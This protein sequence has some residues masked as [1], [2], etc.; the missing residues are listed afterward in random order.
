MWSGTFRPSLAGRTLAVSRG[1]SCSAASLLL[2]C[3]ASPMPCCHPSEPLIGIVCCF[4][5]CRGRLVCCLARQDTHGPANANAAPVWGC[6]CGTHSHSYPRYFAKRVHAVHNC[7]DTTTWEAIIGSD[8]DKG[9]LAHM[10]DGHFY[11]SYCEF[12]WLTSVGASKA[13]FL[14]ELRSREKKQFGNVGAKLKG[15]RASPPSVFSL[16]WVVFEEPGFCGE[17]YLL[18]KGLYG[19]PEDWGALQPR[20]ASAMPV[21]LVRA[22][23]QTKFWNVLLCWGNL[24][25]LDT[26]SHCST[27]FTWAAR[28]VSHNHI[29]LDFNI[30]RL[31]I[32]QFCNIGVLAVFSLPLVVPVWLTKCFHRMWPVMT[33]ILVTKSK[34]KRENR[35]LWGGG[36]TSL[37]TVDYVWEHEAQ[38]KQE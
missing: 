27:A 16:S 9:L 34:F 1:Y 21:V 3:T 14:H 30:L 36:Q 23:T 38:A 37:C 10:I 11:M 26:F 20:I 17:P 29:I 4:S 5:S 32:E 13:V 28:L 18:E 2:D 33:L 6:I 19:S 24:Q 25:L 15:P 12:L 8:S 31:I 7:W 35:N 22:V